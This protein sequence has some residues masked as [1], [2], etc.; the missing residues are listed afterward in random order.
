MK[1]T[2]LRIGNLVQF[3]DEKYRRISMLDGQSNGV[4]ALERIGLCDI[5]DTQPIPLTEELLLKFGFN[6]AGDSEY[7]N[8]KKKFY[9]C[10][11]RDGKTNICNNRGFIKNLKYVHELQNLYFALTGEELTIK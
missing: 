1:A 7:P 5:E 4:I 10:M 9:T 2:E 8:Y 6:N 11:W 3:K